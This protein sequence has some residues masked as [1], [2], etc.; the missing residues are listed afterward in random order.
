MTDVQ[1]SYN[2]TCKLVIDLLNST[3][4]GKQEFIFVTGAA[5]TGKT[6]LIERVKN[7]CRKRKAEKGCCKAFCAMCRKNNK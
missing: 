1:N 6:T 4:S 3:S 2:K 7:Q 5:G